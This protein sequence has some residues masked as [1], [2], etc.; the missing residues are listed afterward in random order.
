MAHHSK[1][2]FQQRAF[3][4]AAGSM[5]GQGKPEATGVLEQVKDTAQDVAST[6][7]E[8]AEDLWDS[9]R[10]GIQQASTAAY[11]QAEDAYLSVTDFMSRYPLATFCTGCCV[12][13]LLMMSCPAYQFVGNEKNR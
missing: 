5:T 13:V 3:T 4:P 1:H 8:Q 6:V 11:D 12:G 10:Q 9:T 2:T 7:A